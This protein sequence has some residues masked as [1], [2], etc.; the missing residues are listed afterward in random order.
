MP[1]HMSSSFPQAVNALSYLATVAMGAT[2]ASLHKLQLAF[3]FLWLHKGCNFGH[4]P[5]HAFPA[6]LVRCD[7]DM[8]SY[9]E[10]SGHFSHLNPSLGAQNVLTGL[11]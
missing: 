3:L 8:T 1:E 11:A 7:D 4:F 5:A 2:T 10:L 9:F 6:R